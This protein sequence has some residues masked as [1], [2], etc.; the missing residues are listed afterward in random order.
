[1]KVK[2]LHPRMPV[3]IFK[4][5]SLTAAARALVDEDI[6]ALVVYE[7]SGLAGVISE[8]D[9][10]RAVVDE[11][12]LDEAEVCEYM[13]ASPVVSDDDAELG[14]AIVKMTQ[15]GIRHVVVTSGDDVT[16]VI[17]MR[18]VVMLFDT[19]LTRTMEAST[20]A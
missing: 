3:T 17:S 14:D 6:G 9:I 7:P 19:H 20:S 15:S 1:M 16:G 4:S 18:D 8:R 12:D 10:V 11:V 13:T 5:E 2:D